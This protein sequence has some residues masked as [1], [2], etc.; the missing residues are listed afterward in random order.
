[1]LVEA[2]QFARLASTAD[3]REG[4]DAWIGRR[5]P[6]FDG[7]WTHISRPSEAR[8]SQLGEPAT[9]VTRPWPAP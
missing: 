1:L 7:S 2:E 8:R 3:L 5:K 9:A 6:A 4:L